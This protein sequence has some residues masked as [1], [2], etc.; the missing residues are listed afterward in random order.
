[1]DANSRSGRKGHP[2]RSCSTGRH[3]RP[4]PSPSD[5]RPGDPVTSLAARRRVAVRPRRPCSAC[6]P[7]E[8][9]FSGS[10]RRHVSHLRPWPKPWSER[11]VRISVSPGRKPRLE[12]KFSGS[13][14]PRD[15][16]A[17]YLISSSSTLVPRPGPPRPR[18]WRPGPRKISAG[19]PLSCAYGK[20]HDVH[21]PRTARSPCVDVGRELTAA[22][23][24]NLKGSL[25]MGVKKS[26]VCNRAMPGGKHTI[27]ASSATRRPSKALV[28][29]VGRK[30]GQYFLRSPVEILALSRRLCRLDQFHHPVPCF[31]STR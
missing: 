20:A 2:S 7:A 28:R 24:P 11:L 12:A 29:V 3:S 6:G 10:G 31:A 15:P 26:T 17:S 18:P 19:W 9:D 5:A 23:R 8:E 21:G 13:R 14:N 4:R 1:M 30:A 22:M 16:P 27:A 25:T